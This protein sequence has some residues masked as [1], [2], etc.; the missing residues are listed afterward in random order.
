MEAL[1]EWLDMLFAFRSVVLL[2]HFHALIAKHI[3][4][5]L[6]LQHIL[7]VRAVV[8]KMHANLS[9]NKLDPSR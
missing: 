2:A 8:K 6:P 1:D 9:Q 7:L 4:R 3:L 5:S